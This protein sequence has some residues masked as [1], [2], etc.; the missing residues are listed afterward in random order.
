[1]A[2][3]SV[4]IEQED[5]KRIERIAAGASKKEFVTAALDYFEKYG[6]NPLKHES[7]AQEMHKLIKRVDQVVA[8]IK[9]QESDMLRPMCEAVNISEQRIKANLDSI[10]TK[11][12]LKQQAQQQTREN[13]AKFEQMVRNISEIF[14]I[15]AKQQAEGFA[16]IGR[17]LDAKE[18]T[19]LIG[20][21][22]K[23]YN[24][25]KR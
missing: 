19:G 8:F 21:I 17:F 1:M 24:Q 3:T 16:H 4:T 9:K 23:T 25:L 20:D 10:A 13:N 7:P 12:D 15:L 5:S 11:N 14:Q 2:T 6:I 18:K 22:G